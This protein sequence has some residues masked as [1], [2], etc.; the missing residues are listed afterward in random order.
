MCAHERMSH[1][2]ENHL[3]SYGNLIDFLL[4]MSTL[5]TVVYP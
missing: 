3:L 2:Q 1:N 4:T 5:K